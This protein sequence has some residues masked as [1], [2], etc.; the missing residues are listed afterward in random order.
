MVKKML[1]HLFCLCS[2]CSLPGKLIDTSFYQ[3]LFQKRE[4]YIKDH[5]QIFQKKKLTDQAQQAFTCLKLTTKRLKQRYEICS[6]LTVKTPERRQ[7]VLGG[8]GH[9]SGGKEMIVFLEN[10]VYALNV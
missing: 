1:L 10:F 8:R 2:I 3:G 9:T 4:P 7:R 5:A 6:K